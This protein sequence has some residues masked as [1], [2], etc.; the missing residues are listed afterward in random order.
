MLYGVAAIGMIAGCFALAQWLLARIYREPLDQGVAPEPEPAL[1]AS[2]RSAN[3][4]D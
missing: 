3:D 1:R 4:R 2:R